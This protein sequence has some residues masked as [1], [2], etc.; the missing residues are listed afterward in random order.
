MKLFNLLFF[1]TA[2]FFT[3]PKSDKIETL[4]EAEMIR[5]NNQVTAVKAQISSNGMY[6]T[7]IA[8]FVDMKI[9]SG[10]NRFFVYDL[11]NDKILYQ[12]LTANGSGSET[13]VSGELKFSNEPNSNS[14]SLGNYAIGK[15]Y[16]GKFG[17]SYKLCGLDATNNNASKRA[18][19]LHSYSAVPEAEQDYYI[20]LS[21]G[22]PMVN[23]VFFKKLEKIIDASKSTIVL[24][25]YY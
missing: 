13:G 15:S 25:I 1:I 7:K 6:N 12:G 8:F 16:Y 5:F 18:I 24:D 14:T 2:S 10:K 4:S 17:K 23:E 11:E 22:C 20:A 19:V 3:A 9:K 21:H